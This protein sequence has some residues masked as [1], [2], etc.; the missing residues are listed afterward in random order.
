MLHTG[1]TEN[2]GSSVGTVTR[3]LAR[4]KSNRGSISEML[5]KFLASPKHPASYVM[6]NGELSP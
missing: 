5:N 6:G 3:L 2:V 1:L 4:R